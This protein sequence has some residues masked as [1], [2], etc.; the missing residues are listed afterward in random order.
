MSSAFQ[1]GTWAVLPPCW[2]GR[3]GEAAM[4]GEEG[5]CEE[6]VAGWF[7]GCERTVLWLCA[8]PAA[9]QHSFSFPLEKARG[10]VRTAWQCTLS[11]H[12]HAAPHL[13]CDP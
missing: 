11:S 6:K 7:L 12:P 9:G 10:W 3:Q 13:L 5:S 8:G 1:G 2:E 4:L